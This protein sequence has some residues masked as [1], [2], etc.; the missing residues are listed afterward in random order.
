MKTVAI[1]GLLGILLVPVL[2]MSA[3]RISIGTGPWS[4]AYFPVGE[5][6]AKI[7]NSTSPGSKQ[8]QLQR[9]ARPMHSILINHTA[10]WRGIGEVKW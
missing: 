8:S 4:G 1:V 6:L 7:L 9:S 5:A 3:T 10:Y 2:G